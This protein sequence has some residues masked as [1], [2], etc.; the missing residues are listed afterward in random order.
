MKK[1][2][3]IILT[4]FFMVGADRAPINKSVSKKPSFSRKRPKNVPIRKPKLYKTHKLIYFTWPVGLEMFGTECPNKGFIQE[5]YGQPPNLLYEVRVECKG[6]IDKY[7]HFFLIHQS[8]V[9]KIVN[10]G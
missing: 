7:D 9:V 5:V 1:Y 2:M 3:A 8:Q 4:A 6:N 10:R